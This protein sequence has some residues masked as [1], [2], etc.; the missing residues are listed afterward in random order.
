MVAAVWI[1]VYLVAINLV[2][3]GVFALD[4]HFARTRRWR[5]REST[6][7]NFALIGGSFGAKMAQRHLRHK[8]YKQP[9]GRRLNWIIALQGV[10]VVAGGVLWISPEAQTAAMRILGDLG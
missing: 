9:F 1:G 4:K 3:F 5:I 6:L 7:L 8:S 2:T 10:L